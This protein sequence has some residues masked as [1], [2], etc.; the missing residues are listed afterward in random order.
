MLLYHAIDTGAA[1]CDTINSGSEQGN[2]T[3]S[4]PVSNNHVT[5]SDARDTHYLKL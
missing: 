1:L 3:D 5:P 4:I 2:L